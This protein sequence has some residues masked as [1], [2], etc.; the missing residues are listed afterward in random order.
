VSYLSRELFRCQ[1]LFLFGVFSGTILS[2]FARG[3]QVKRE[4]AE[5]RAIT[6]LPNEG[7]LA[8]VMTWR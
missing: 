5:S 6:W 7:Y 1:S 4:V 3:Q 2:L 8:Q